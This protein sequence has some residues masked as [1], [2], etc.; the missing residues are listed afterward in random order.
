[1]KK[2]IKYIVYKIERAFIWSSGADYSVLIQVPIEKSKFLGIG[3]TI[4]FTALMASFAGG[5]AFFTAFRE[6]TNID[7]SSNPPLYT[8]SSYFFAIFF[9]MFW[10]ALIFNLDRYIV[11]TFGVGDGKKTISRQE[12]IE[13]TPRLLM[14]I[15]LGLVIS[16]PLELKIFEKEI[17]VKLEQLKLNKKELLIHDDKSFESDLTN[18]KAL[19]T[20]TNSQIKNLTEKKSELIENSARFFDLHKSE[21]KEDWNQKNAQVKGD[22]TKK[23]IAW[24]NYLK[25][26]NDSTKSNYQIS[27]ALQNYNL[28]YKSYIESKQERTDIENQISK[29]Q[30]D[31]QQ[32]RV[33]EMN[34][35]NS[36][37]ARLTNEATNLSQKI[38]QLGVTESQKSKGYDDI[39]KNYN[40][41]AAHLEA[42]DE[43]SNERVTL[44]IARWLITLL[45][46]L[47]E[48]A[49]VLFKMMSERGP[50]DDIVDR[51]K[52]EIKVKQLQI[53]SNLNQEVNT[54]VRI[55]SEKFDQKF[56]AEL[57]ANKELLDAISKAQ[58]EIAVVAIEKWKQEEITKIANGKSNIISSYD[59]TLTI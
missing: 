29:L 34:R 11:S 40:G 27:S 14:A 2:L 36:E 44:R 50:Y 3:G 45:F 6:A 46:I 37:I 54:E 59:K 49:P 21:I 57:H 22:E 15:I 20:T 17:N 33:D 55:H 58:Y 10:G 41:F 12:I 1:M 8:F 25:I 23:N 31:K 19:L 24:I 52:Y 48:I 4:L 43:V 5:Y 13:A 26:K 47:I 56:I 9:G 18:K 28:I 53:Q 51:I 7:T 42:M 16:T 39:V 38:S 35:L 30:T 32:A